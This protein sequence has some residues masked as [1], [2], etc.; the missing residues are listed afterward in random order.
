MKKLILITFGFS[1]SLGVVAVEKN[2][3]LPEFFQRTN[4]EI[5]NPMEL[6]DPFKRRVQ[7]IKS[8]AKG[9]QSGNRTLFSNMPTLENVPLDKIKILGVILGDNRR[10][11]ART[12]SDNEG[13]QGPP[14]PSQF[15]QP[16]QSGQPVEVEKFPTYVI[17]EGMRLGNNNAEVR[18]ILPGGVVLVEKI[19]NVYDQEEYIETIIPVTV[20]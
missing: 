9:I 16:G 12:I 11:I 1:V 19:R 17:T 14:L 2:K 6:R 15:Q 3:K 4:T 20:D 8:S 7:K 5:K 10:A 18:A 13:Q